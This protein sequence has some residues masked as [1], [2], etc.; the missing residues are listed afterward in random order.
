MNTNILNMVRTLAKVVLPLYLFTLL[1]LASCSVDDV[2]PQG[3]LD[4]ETAFSS[5][6]KLVTAAYAKLGDDW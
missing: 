1:P 2:K 6:E 5:P 3:T 4:E